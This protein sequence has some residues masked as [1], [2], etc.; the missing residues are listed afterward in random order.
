MK[1]IYRLVGL[2]FII[3]MV[4]STSA[5]AELGYFRQPAISGDTLVFVAEGD[6]WRTAAS[7]GVAQRLTT[8][9]SEESNPAISP[10][11]K[12]LAFTARY[13]GPAEVYVMPI[14]GGQPT[15]LTFEGDAARVQGWTPDGKVIYATARYSGKPTMRL[16]TVDRQTR[17]SLPIAL[18]EAA[19][20]CYQFN[21]G[22]SSSLFFT[23][24]P[25]N[26][27]NVKRY[28]GGLVQQI[29]KFDANINT[30]ANTKANNNAEAILLTGDYKGTSRQ[31]MCGTCSAMR[32]AM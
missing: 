32:L 23:R 21:N 4:V 3:A 6:L 11:G 9:P 26:S 16:Y 28:Q 2:S 31:P 19:E 7:G 8:H 5:H 15:R 1:H 18:A 30:N 29:W 14:S 20:G 24:Q 25:L 12:W 13:E 17:A 22:N 10:D 27:D